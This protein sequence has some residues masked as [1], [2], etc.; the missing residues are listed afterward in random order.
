MTEDGFEEWLRE[1]FKEVVDKDGWGV[2]YRDFE[3]DIKVE[4]FEGEI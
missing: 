2:A 1:Q 4:N 3:V